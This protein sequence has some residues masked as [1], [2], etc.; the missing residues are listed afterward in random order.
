MEFGVLVPT[1]SWPTLDY[2]TAAK[3]KEFATKAEALGFDSI[4][5]SEHLLTAPGLYG[6]AWLSPMLCLAHMAAVTQRITL[7]TD[8]LILPTRNPVATAKEIATLDSLSAGRYIL[9]VGVGWDE[10]EFEVS[11]VKF[12]ERGGRTDEALSVIRRLLTESRVTHHGRYYHFDDVTIDPHCGRLPP[13]WIAGGSKIKT[14]LSPDPPEIAPGVLARIARA[15][16]WTSR[17]AGTQEMVKADWQ[18][19]V[20]FCRTKGRDPGTLTFCHTNFLHLVST[21]DREEALRRQRPYFERIMGTHRS[22]EHVQECYL[23]GTTTEIVARLT[24]LEQAGL[25]HV[26]LAPL[27]YDL[28]QI[29]RYAGEILPHFRK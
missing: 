16:G 19:I 11:G 25:H 3:I 4:W 13:I 27:D 5:T 29:E 12:S 17:S 21:T 2:G 24:D 18:K 8:I 22:W 20:D 14:A 26:V 9:G 6:T 15:D 7:G 23:T 1:F 10:H 28:E